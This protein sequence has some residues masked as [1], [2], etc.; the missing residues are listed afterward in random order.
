[1]YET[2]GSENKKPETFWGI[3]TQP[4]RLNA[5]LRYTAPGSKI[6]D[7][8]SGR[9]AYTET[10]NLK[11]FP[12]IGVDTHSYA[13]WK[14]KPDEWFVQASA[15]SLAFKNKE[16][17]TTICFEVLE[18]CPEPEVVLNEITRVTSNK[19]ILSVPNCNLNNA[20][21]K[22]D[23][24]LAH[25][26]D[27]THCNFFTKDTIQALLH[28]CGYRII[29]ISDCYQISPNEY[30]WENIR[31]PKKIAKIAKKTCEKFKLIETYWS[32]ILIVAEVPK[33]QG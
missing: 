32:S 17:D 30:F 19:L 15:S 11:N 29:E 5:V 4:E 16:F 21:R 12:T 22:Y 1:M 25:W 31:L 9:G 28:E 20:L 26:T 27:P 3:D 7:L 33:Q 14:T 8:G 23:L 24:A 2:R 10:L 13:E 6:L 18:H